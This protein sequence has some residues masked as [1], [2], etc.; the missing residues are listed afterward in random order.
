MSS[1][2]AGKSTIIE[3]L[4]YVLG[5]EPIGEDAKRVYN[6]IVQGVLRS[7]TKIS[8]AVQSYR[9]DKRLFVIQRTVPSAPRVIDDK[10]NVLP[11]KPLDVVRGGGRLRTKRTI[12]AG[13]QAGKTNCASAS[14]HPN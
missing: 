6:S 4:R 9:P 7:G 12:R 11:V 5:I 2:V 1:L 13:T 8:L 14:V 3:S 10:G